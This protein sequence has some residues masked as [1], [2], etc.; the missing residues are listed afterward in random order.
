MSNSEMTL[1]KVITLVSVVWTAAF[2]FAESNVDE[3]SLQAD[4]ARYQRLL[5]DIQAID[6]ECNEVLEG[7][8][9][10]TKKYG[11]ASLELKSRLIGLRNKRDRCM[12]RLMLISLRH[13]WEMPDAKVQK[14][15]NAADEMIKSEREQLFESADSMLKERFA[16]QARQIASK[17]ILPV[18][19]MRTKE[20]TKKENQRWLRL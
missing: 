3:R 5:R 6:S 9:A 2:A 4:K 10:E 1:I 18:I 15:Q 7:A 20:Q 12:N 13:G 16:Q 17:V 11:K 19:S 14:V 8:V